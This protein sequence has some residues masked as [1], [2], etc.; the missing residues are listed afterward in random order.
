MKAKVKIKRKV[1]K[2][3]E[4]KHGTKTLYSML[5][6][7]GNKELWA[8]CFSAPV[9]DA[10]KE[11]DTVE[12]ELVKNGKFWN[13]VVPR[14]PEKASQLTEVLDTLKRLETK[15]DAITGNVKASSDDITFDDIPDTTKE[16]PKEEDPFAGATSSD[17]EIPF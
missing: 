15:I 17:E 10:W 13:I 3:I 2:D 11:G 6:M 12:L 4:T 16:L 5:L 14:G 9:S 8:S 7:S 1:T